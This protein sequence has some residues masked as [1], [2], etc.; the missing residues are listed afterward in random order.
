MPCTLWLLL[1]TGYSVRLLIKRKC[2][3]GILVGACRTFVLCL[4]E[5]VGDGTGSTRDTVGERVI[6]GNLEK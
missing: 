6:A 5:L 3:D 2:L 1:P 4:V